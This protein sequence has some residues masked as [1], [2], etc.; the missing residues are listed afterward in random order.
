MTF[1]NGANR[2]RHNKPPRFRFT[3][4]DTGEGDGRE[5]SD[6]STLLVSA[7]HAGH[8]GEHGAISHTPPPF[9]LSDRG[10]V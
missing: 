8:M 5:R 10:I 9:D 1:R 7:Y 6:T 3:I 2:S 4:P